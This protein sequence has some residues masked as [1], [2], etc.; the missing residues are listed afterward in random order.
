MPDDNLGRTLAQGLCVPGQLRDDLTSGVYLPKDPQEALGRYE[1]TLKLVTEA[2]GVYHKIVK[3]MKA[4]KLPR[5]KPDR[6]VKKAL[7]ANVITKEDFDLVQA[8]EAARDDAIQVDSFKLEDFAT[9]LL[10]PN[11]KANASNS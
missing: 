10:T 9:N 4:K 3:A 7:E 1:H 11:D 8:A 2:N 6:L 5:G